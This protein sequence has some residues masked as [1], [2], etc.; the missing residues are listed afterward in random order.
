MYVTTYL[1]NFSFATN[2]RRISR[3]KCIKQKRNHFVKKEKKARDLLNVRACCFPETEVEEKNAE[4]NVT[5][6]F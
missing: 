5:G 2:F 4:K 3:E 6:I 1:S